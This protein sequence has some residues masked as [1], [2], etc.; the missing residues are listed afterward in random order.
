MDGFR[1]NIAA[2]GAHLT[3]SPISTQ[4]E[5]ESAVDV[6]HVA[7]VGD[8]GYSHLTVAYT[9]NSP[10][11]DSPED[12]HKDKKLVWS[13][14]ASEMK[15]MDTQSFTPPK[16]GLLEGGVATIYNLLFYNAF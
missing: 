11:P 9:N 8:D 2:C 7:F 16:T 15:H 14:K 1:W 5:V 10:F 13:G 4:F 6:T 12:L 3:S